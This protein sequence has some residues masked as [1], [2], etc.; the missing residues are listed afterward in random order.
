MSKNAPNQE[1]AKQKSRRGV[2]YFTC[3]MV[4]VAALLVGY[5]V[6]TRIDQ[7]FISENSLSSLRQTYKELKLNFDGELN[8]KKLIEGA[9]RG[10]VEAAGDPYTVFLDKNE[11]K[12][13]EKDLEGT[14]SGIG[15]ELGKKD[16][17]LVVISALDSSPAKKA[18]LQPNDIVARV[19]GADSSDWSIDKAVSKIRGKEGTK[20]KLT[21]VR[22]EEVI[23]LT[24]TRDTITDPSV[25]TEEK[26]GVGIIR[27]SSFGEKTSELTRQAA[28]KFK[29][30]KGII[31]DLRGNGGGYLQSAQEIA[32]LWIDEGE[33]IVTERVGG[34]V[35]QT[36]N[37]NGDNILGNVPTVVLIDQGSAS[38]SEIVAGA[39]KD[40]KKAT[41]VG[42]RSFGKGS[43]QNMIDL[44]NG[45]KLKVT[46]A[47]WYTPSGRNIGKSGIM[48]DIK[49]AIGKNDDKEHDSQLQK[50]LD[51]VK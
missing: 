30:K 14:F 40:A 35:R 42:Q 17:K 44:A 33:A 46:I 13:F 24:I 27:I 34:E 9:N 11:A 47:K 7:L 8:D 31:V 20:V 48:P 32:S 16:D 4:V 39:L 41:L 3:T 43:V 10:L 50:A 21:L 38:A 6:G 49:V 5:V 36:H 19:N 18:G 12:E 22:G 45:A 28:E 15:A 51:I 37:A 2:S 1:D 25:K 26:D 29:N 23:D